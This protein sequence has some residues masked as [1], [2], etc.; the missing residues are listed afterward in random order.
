MRQRQV[1]ASIRTIGLLLGVLLDV[2]GTSTPAAGAC[3]GPLPP[4][5]RRA[6]QRGPPGHQLPGHRPTPGIGPDPAMSRIARRYQ[7]EEA[8][9]DPSCTSGPVW[10]HLPDRCRGLVSGCRAQGRRVPIVHRRAKLA[11]DATAATGR[12]DATVLDDPRQVTPGRRQEPLMT[13]AYIVE[14]VT[15]IEPALSAWVSVPSGP[16][17]WP[18]LQR[19]VSATDRERPLVTGVNGP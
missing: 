10:R 17:T 14:R 1:T 6:S 15:G 7:H 3:A 5:A 18:D 4:D 11:L 16:V 19:G 12:P 13:C 8:A 2:P 9:H